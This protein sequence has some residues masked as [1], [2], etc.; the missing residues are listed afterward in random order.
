MNIV[1]VYIFLF[2]TF[3]ES[4]NTFHYRQR[5]HA[6]DLRNADRKRAESFLYASMTWFSSITNKVKIKYAEKS[7]NNIVFHLVNDRQ[8]L[9][10]CCVFVHLLSDYFHSAFADGYTVGNRRRRSGRYLSAS[11]KETLLK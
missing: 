8:R 11:L 3:L 2:I 10:G 7:A 6:A 4:E 1:S 5:N 9:C